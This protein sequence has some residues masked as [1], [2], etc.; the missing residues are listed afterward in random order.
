MTSIAT[1]PVFSPS[2][3]GVVVGETLVSHVDGDR[4]ALTYRSHDIATL[5]DRP[6]LEVAWLLLFGDWPDAEQAQQF[7]EFTLAHSRLTAAELQLLQNLDKDLHPMLMLQAVVPT[8]QYQELAPLDPPDNSSAI[9]RGLAIAAKLPSLLA[10][11]LRLQK[12]LKPLAGI[13]QLN[14]NENF[15]WQLHGNA[16]DELAVQTLNATQ[17]LQMEHSYNASTFAGR[18]CASTNAPI[19]SVL[20]A[21]IGTLF[22][23]LHGGAD[24]AALEMAQAIGGAENASTYVAHCMQA[25]TKIMGMGHREYKAL[26]PRAA[27][28]K[29]MA[30]D[31]CKDPDSKQLFKTLV[32]VEDSC[33]QY[34]AKSGKQIWANV[35]FYKGAVFHAL[36]IPTHFFTGVFAMARVYGYIAHYAEF[37]QEPRLIRPRARYIGVKS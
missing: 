10:A 11:W 12:G 30:A 13:G 4:G 35:E 5:I 3:E 26:D 1:T 34:F 18:V 33:Q 36:G 37:I 25:K 20:S 15:L 28:L 23:S 2:L 9:H 6:V 21:S 19:Q 16:P 32:A 17:V 24:Q 8:L 27:I 22:G 7:A 31:L 14:P 29:P